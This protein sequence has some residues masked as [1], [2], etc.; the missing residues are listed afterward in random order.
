ML[1]PSCLWDRAGEWMADLEGGGQVG[2]SLC[3]RAV[4]VRSKVG[5]ASLDNVEMESERL[6]EYCQAVRTR[7]R[8]RP[9]I[10]TSS[11]LAG[12]PVLS[13]LRV[14]HT[15]G[16]SKNIQILCLLSLCPWK[17]LFSES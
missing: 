5:V 13:L 15:L 10:L 12:V 16:S 17:I 1:P 4:K 6:T 11:D 2:A 3:S 7:V 9:E 14:C 8:T